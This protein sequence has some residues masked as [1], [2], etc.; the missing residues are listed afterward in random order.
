MT[1]TN[2]PGDE[3]A[4]LLKKYAPTGVVIV[5]DSN[6]HESAVTLLKADCETVASAPVIS[7]PAGEEQKGLDTVQLIWNQLT[8]LGVTKEWLAVNVGGG[9]LTDIA[10]FAES[11]FK[12]GIDFINIPTTLLGAVDAAI[13]GKT[14]FN[15]KGLKNQIGT[16][17]PA[18]DVIVSTVYFNTLPEQELLS[19]YAEMLKHALLSSDKML[20]KLLNYSL[21]YPEFDADALLPLIEESVAVK[22]TIVASDPTEKGPRKA[23]NLGHT[24]GHAFEELA[25]ERNS[26]VPHGYAVAWGLCAALILS[27]L[28]I[29][30][31]SDTL[32]SFA[33]YVKDNYGT[34]GI[35]CDD[36]PRLIALMGEDKKNTVTGQPSFTLLKAVGQPLINQTAPE[37]EITTTL[38]I[39]RDLLD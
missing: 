26:P 22:E 5:C 2:H 14:G 33:K 16:F 15:F 23:L 3:L 27:N 32:H 1:F 18:K 9:V 25:F 39:L 38:D 11:T 37:K 31:P 30:F 28:T 17:T 10:G 13:G 6:T 36:Y 12:R 34:P 19:G 4:A 29:G 20:A 24:F 35:T 21:L 8:D 7:I